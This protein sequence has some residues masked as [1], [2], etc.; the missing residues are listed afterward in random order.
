MTFMWSVKI[1]TNRNLLKSIFEFDEC[2]IQFSYTMSLYIHMY[3]GVS[4]LKGV[5]EFYLNFILFTY[6]IIVITISILHPVYSIYEDFTHLLFYNHLRSVMAY[7]IR[8]INWI[9]KGGSFYFPPYTSPHRLTLHFQFPLSC[10]RMCFFHSMCFY[11]EFI[12]LP[13]NKILSL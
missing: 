5:V 1:L 3:V 7:E 8:K 12:V 11:R 10:M 4:S 2:S 6:I 13:G 9:W